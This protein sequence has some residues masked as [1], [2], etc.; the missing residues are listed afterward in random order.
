MKAS[1]PWAHLEKQLKGDIEMTEL[2]RILYATDASVY[3]SKP[4]GVV[5]PK[6]S[7]D[8]TAIIKFAS[9]H[10]VSLIPR[11]AG[12]SLAGQC[13]GLGI[14]VDV[15]RYMTRILE[16]NVE[17][18]WVEVEPGVV[19]DELNLHLA[20]YG[21][22]FGPNTST[23]NRCMMGGMLG[24]NSSGSTSIKYGVTRDKVMMVE[25]IL[26][27]GSSA[28]F[29]DLNEEEY[30]G[31]LT[32]DDLEGTIYRG[33]KELLS[34][35]EVQ[36]E[37]RSQFPDERIKRRNTGYA[38]DELIKQKP[39]YPNGLPLNLS[40][41]LAGSEGTLCFTTRVR[42]HLDLLPP[43]NEAVICAHFHNII[44]AMQATVA[45]MKMEPYAC[46]LMDD[47][48]LEL[49]KG[50]PT[51]NENRFFVEG[52]PGAVLVVEVRCESDSDFSALVQKSIET[53][54]NE[55]LAYATPVV[56]APNTTKVWALRAAGLGVLS[57]MSGDAKPIAFV[58]DTAVAIENLPAYISDFERLME[59]FGQE[60]IYYAHAG[61]GELHLRPVLDL[62]SK[63][64][65][66]DFRRIAEAS[67]KLVKQYKGSLSG[68]HGDGR[69]RAELI[70]MVLGQKNYEVLKS[71]KYLWDE[72]N[73]FNRGKIVDAFPIDEDFR[74][75]ENQPKF[76]FPTFMNFGE[77][78]MLQ[79][80]ERCNGSG[81]C[82]KSAEF[83]A[84]M[85]PSYQVTKNEKDSTR[86]RAN[87]LR[88]IMTHPENP[89]Y[90]LDSDEVRDVLDL[91]LS[92]KACSRDCPSSV[93]M[94]ALKAEATYQYQRRHG[95]PK[96]AHF[97]GKFH[98]NAERAWPFRALANF[99]LKTDYGNRVFKSYFG[100]ATERTIP[101]FSKSRGSKRA[102]KY[103][104]KKEGLD[105][106]LYID[107]FT[108]FQDAEIAE[109]AAAFFQKIGLNFKVIYSPS[110]RSEISK[111][112]LDEGR[113][114][115]EQ[116][117]S[118]LYP[119][120]T[121]DLPIVGLEPSAI[122]GFRDDIPKLVSALISEKAKELSKRVFT[123]EEFV[124]DLIVRGKLRA[125][126]FTEAPLELAIHLHCHQKSL[127][128]IKHSKAILNLPL[129]Y[130]AVA[131][132]SGC[133]GMAGS[134]GFEEKHYALS[135]DIGGLVLFPFLRKHNGKT[136]VATGTSCRHQIKDGVAVKSH[137]PAEILLRALK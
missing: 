126:Q 103:H 7:E 73:I 20:Q 98:H 18:R 59:G 3:R 12:T 61:A 136:V 38:I 130:H 46:E 27:D 115:V 106:I 43:K 114:S 8:V 34:P 37:I 94:A 54:Q 80:S 104:S 39:F 47:K 92:C 60:A 112:L 10:D 21:L 117:I 45:I 86:A 69:V 50:N 40:K 62:K 25:G 132:P 111:G 82:R 74:Y 135:Q 88:E 28:V 116:A 96:S 85:C 6:D 9:G 78:N 101:Q 120:C 23:S 65:R 97:F 77:E 33:L 30:Q 44:D 51:Q 95:V 129:N 1:I 53:I 90:P 35:K 64:G 32:Q 70:P 122:L 87:V 110:G 4:L 49:T 36:E 72:K 99:V 16:V 11:A 14:V 89:A 118:Q 137:H 68:E 15:S 57:N 48:I 31:K 105:F 2:S 42:F 55:T 119:Y 125:S 58:E 107:E 93:D 123:F 71:V 128:H 124:H 22:F 81:D 121:N 13:V 83:G 131:I 67:A 75:T 102:A 26:A 100:I 63:Q 113:K 17:E 41:L 134:F 52:N 109:Y 108:E 5:F 29:A 19:R 24:N 133:C 127:S 91:C 84:T 56:Y 66:K 79:V 76:S